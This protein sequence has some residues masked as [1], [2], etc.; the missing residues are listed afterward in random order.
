MKRKSSPEQS[1]RKLRLLVHAIDGCVP[2]LSPDVLETHFPPSDD[3]WIGLA[4]KDV[5][6]TPS[7]EPKHKDTKGRKGKTAKKEQCVQQAKKPRGY[8]F[9]P[10]SPDSWL[11]PYTRVTVASFDW[12]QE[13]LD[14]KSDHSQ[15]PTEGSSTTN[16]HILVWTP[17]GRQKLAPEA[18]AKA[19]AGL[20]SK[21][22]LSLYDMFEDYSEKR[23]RKAIERNK[24]WFLDLQGKHSESSGSDKYLWS[25]ILLPKEVP[26]AGETIP[27]SHP[28]DSDEVAGVALIGKWN[29]ELETLLEKTLEN[30]PHVALLATY[31]LREF[32]SAAGSTLV[33]TI[34]SDLPRVWTQKK[35]AL[36]V[37]CS[38]TT[39]STKKLKTEESVESQPM[40][41]LGEEGCLDMNDKQFARDPQPLVPGCQ[42][43][44]CSDSR[45]SRAYVHH[46]ICAKELLADILL[47]GHNLH[48]LI[49]LTKALNE[50]D[51]RTALIQAIQSQLGKPVTET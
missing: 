44:A 26:K 18:Y 20:Q 41:E 9:Q 45:F 51:D 30:V 46:L 16:K 47:F 34:G 12:L 6:V 8:T 14:H 13:H 19:S 49:Q 33:D 27:V 38:L 2:F 31:S 40:L 28:T 4:V 21:F 11:L 15:Q 48:S 37:D 32:L 23:Q 17:H 24:A 35:M 39:T 36:A 25:P 7:F 43:L 1:R 29:S 5:C 10:V 50:A 22:T 3:W 42:C